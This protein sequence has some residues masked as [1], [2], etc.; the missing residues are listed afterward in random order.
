M[1]KNKEVENYSEWFHE[2]SDDWFYLAVTVVFKGA[3]G[4]GKEL[5]EQD[6]KQKVLPKIQ[7]CVESN[8]KNF[9]KALPL[10]VQ[11]FYYEKDETSLYK[12]V[13][14][15]S[16]H[17]IH[18]LVIVPRSRLHRVWSVDFGNLQA[19]LLR[20]IMSVESVASFHV[21][22][23]KPEVLSGWLRYVTKGGKAL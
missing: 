8:P 21:S 4:M 1:S 9:A 19:K 11:L 15:S 3:T 14:S 12:K 5:A 10:D 20:D 2:R 16:P 13:K 6:Y 22:E 7:R 17:H 23:A 18:G